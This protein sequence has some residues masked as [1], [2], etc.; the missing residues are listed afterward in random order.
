MTRPRHRRDCHPMGATP[1]PGCAGL[2]EHLRRSEIQRP[3]PPT[4]ITQV[5]SRR[6]ATAQPAPTTR[7]RDWPHRHHDRLRVV[8]EPTPST[9]VRVSPHARSHTLLSRTPPYL[10]VRSRQATPNLGIRRGAL[11]D[12]HCKHPRMQQENQI[13][14][15]VHMTNQ[16]TREGERP[17]LARRGHCHGRATTA[18]RGT[19]HDCGR[20]DLDEQLGKRQRLHTEQRA[21]GSDSGGAETLAEHTG[22]CEVGLDV[23]R[24]EVRRTSLA[25]GMSA[26]RNTAS[27]LSAAE[28]E[29]SSHVG[30]I[31]GAPSRRPRS[32]PRSRAYGSRLPRAR[33]G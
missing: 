14:V 23:G 20:L 3:P 16:Q 12:Q 2:E 32:G 5:V 8:V 27:R 13:C 24:V 4:T 33:P 6:A 7:P 15:R 1:N 26:A 21:G 28:S 10:P 29:L 9:T 18:S 17:P 19:S 25:N 11:A 31:L 30:D 22:V